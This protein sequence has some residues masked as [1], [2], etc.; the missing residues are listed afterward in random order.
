MATADTPWAQSHRL[1]LFNQIESRPGPVE[2]D[3]TAWE[4]TR[5]TG[6]VHLLCNC[7]F[8]TGWIPRTRMPTPEE[9]KAQ[10][11]VPFMSMSS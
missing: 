3:G 1:H 7:G 4:E 2:A 9:L 6:F 10:H 8:S 5:A 11:G